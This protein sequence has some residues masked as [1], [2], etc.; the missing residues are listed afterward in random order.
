M[1]ADAPQVVLQPGEQPDALQAGPVKRIHIRGSAVAACK[2]GDPQ[3][4][5]VILTQ[6]EAV[7][8]LCFECEWEGPARIIERFANPLPSGTGLWIETTSEVRITR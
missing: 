8:Y 2:H 5:V 6:D 3:P 4:C 7:V 1:P